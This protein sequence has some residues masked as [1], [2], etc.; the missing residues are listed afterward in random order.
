[1]CDGWR[2]SSLSLS[3]TDLRLASLPQQLGKLAALRSLDLSHTGIAGHIP[4][5]LL[6][7][8]SNLEVLSLASNN[9]TGT[10]PPEL[11]NLSSLRTLDLSNN[12]LQG[13]IPSSLGVPGLAKL[14]FLDLSNNSLTGRLPGGFAD[15]R[16]LESL[17]VSDN[18]GIC[19]GPPAPAPGTTLIAT[20]EAFNYTGTHLWMPCE[21]LLEIRA[22]PDGEETL[23][24]RHSSSGLLTTTLQVCGLLTIS[25]TQSWPWKMLPVRSAI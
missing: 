15:M 9:L 1:M 20:L 17:D 7:G 23:Q 16:A 6:A 2:V 13:T 8:L 5:Q 14:E 18:C 25:T 19:G 12:S 11:G 10:I 22:C 4:P 21:V 24:A 3:G